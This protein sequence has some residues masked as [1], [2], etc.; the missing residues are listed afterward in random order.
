MCIWLMKYG[1]CEHFPD[2]DTVI[3]A[4]KKFVSAGEDFMTATCKLLFIV[5]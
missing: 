4:V 1:L 2:D 3:G 5:G